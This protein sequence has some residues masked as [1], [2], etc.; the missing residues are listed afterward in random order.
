MIIGSLAQ[1]SPFT[2]EH[3]GEDDAFRGDRR[4]FFK[5]CSDWLMCLDMLT[6]SPGFADV[7]S[8]QALACCRVSGVSR[9][10]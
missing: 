10:W 6:I 8:K 9:I 7:T 3:P 5:R 4:S 1:G 2:K